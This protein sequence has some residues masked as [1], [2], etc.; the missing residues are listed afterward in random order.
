MKNAEMSFVA[1]GT[2]A[3]CML[4]NLFGFLQCVLSFSGF[5]CFLSQATLSRSCKEKVIFPRGSTVRYIFAFHLQS[6][7]RIKSCTIITKV[8]RRWSK[9]VRNL[10][11]ECPIFV[12]PLPL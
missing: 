8:T 10:H 1:P 4:E 5:L 2:S 11:F 3:R 7:Q 12:V 9:H 6:R